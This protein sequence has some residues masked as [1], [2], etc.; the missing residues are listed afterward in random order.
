[1]NSI[2]VPFVRFIQLILPWSISRCT[3]VRKLSWQMM[4]PVFLYSHTLI[5]FIS[6]SNYKVSRVSLQKEGH[7]IRASKSNPSVQK[8]NNEWKKIVLKSKGYR[9]MNVSPCCAKLRCFSTW[10]SASIGTFIVIVS[11]RFLHFPLAQGIVFCVSS[12]W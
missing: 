3:R 10:F 7:F 9:S 12:N 6:M 2:L 4:T 11:L 1:M 5:Y 8:N